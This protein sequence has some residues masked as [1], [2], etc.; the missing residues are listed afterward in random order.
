MSKRQL[1]KAVL[2]TSLIVTFAGVAEPV[3]SRITHIQINSRAVAYGGAS[4]PWGSTRRSE[5]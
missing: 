4:E 1:V 3:Q 2:T 5:G